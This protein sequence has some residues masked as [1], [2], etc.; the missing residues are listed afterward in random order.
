MEN[1]KTNSHSPSFSQLFRQPVLLFGFGFGSGLIKPGPGTWGTLLGFL[2]FIPLMQWS[3]EMAWLLFAISILFGNWICGRSAEIMGVHDH[4]GIVWDEFAGIWLTLLL[5]PEQSLVYW[6]MAF[7]SFRI[8]DIAKPQP[9]KWA[10]HKVSG[11][12]GI[13]LDDILAAVYA[14]LLIWLMHYGFFV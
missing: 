8:F 14:L 13:M 1:K 9:I 12:M 10:D 3:M 7:V 2:L 6:G 5:L 11:G 4:G